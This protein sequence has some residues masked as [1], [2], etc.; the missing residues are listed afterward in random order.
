MRSPYGAAVIPDAAGATHAFFS[1][2]V[3]FLEPDERVT[4]F[5]SLRRLR[6]V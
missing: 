3:G 2:R 4:P 5:G 6:R 1:V